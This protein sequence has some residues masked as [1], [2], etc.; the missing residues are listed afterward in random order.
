MVGR[1][2]IRKLEVPF[3]LGLT[4]I[5]ANLLGSSIGSQLPPGTPNPLTSIG[6]SAAQF[7]GLAGTLALTGIALEETRNLNPNRNRKRNKFKVPNVQLVRDYG[8]K[9]PL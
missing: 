1:K 6:T 2:T 7:A 8:K 9:I 5:G 4:S 3:G